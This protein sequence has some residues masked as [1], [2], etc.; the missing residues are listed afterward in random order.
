MKI[1]LFL[2]LLNS[3]NVVA[4]P[5]ITRIDNGNYN[6][7]ISFAILGDGYTTMQQERFNA[8]VDTICAR[9]NKFEPYKTYHKFF[10]VFGFNIISNDSGITDLNTS[11]RIDNYFGSNIYGSS[12][13]VTRYLDAINIAQTSLTRTDITVV[14]ANSTRRGGV[15]TEGFFGITIPSDAEYTF[16]HELGHA[17]GEL[18]D[19]YAPWYTAVAPNVT[20]DTIHDLIKWK[21]WIPQNAALPTPLNKF[22]VGAYPVYGYNGFFSP[23]SDCMMRSAYAP[24]CRI[25]T[26]A[27]VLQIHK[28]VKMYDTTYPAIGTINYLTSEIPFTLQMVDTTNLKFNVKWYLNNTEIPDIKG[29]AYSLDPIASNLGTGNHILKCRFKDT[30]T[31]IY[32]KPMAWYQ[33]TCP[34]VRTDPDSIMTDSVVWNLIYGT[35]VELASNSLPPQTLTASITSNGIRIAANPFGQYAITVHD[36]RG[37]LLA[38]IDRGSTMRNVVQMYRP[39]ASGLV[40][41][42][43][44]TSKGAHAAKV[45]W[46]R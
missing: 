3:F 44:I 36:I 46:V 26:E 37:R 1:I 17:L 20:K 12:F 39:A 14:I 21:A 6:N 11:V 10:N 41:V 35:A 25:C 22:Y 27:I 31:Y 45:V 2:I 32:P 23:E 38:N 8:N 30:T 28:K 19:E 34:F 43:M 42:R 18:D 9:L 5:Y 15:G 7:R 40:V 4:I 29:F 13:R 16:L 33:D 24:F